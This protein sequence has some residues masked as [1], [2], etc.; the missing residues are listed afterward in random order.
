MLF[1]FSNFAT[2]RIGCIF[3][4]LQ[5]FCFFV[6]VGETCLLFLG[7]LCQAQMDIYTV[8]VILDFGFKVCFHILKSYGYY[9]T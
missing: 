9:K 7:I 1:V 6:I 8:S 5:D 3:L 2:L 4:I